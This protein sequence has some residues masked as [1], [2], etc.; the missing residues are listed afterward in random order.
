[1]DTRIIKSDR[2]IVNGPGEH[3]WKVALMQ[4][5]K[6]LTM[7]VRGL[8]SPCDCPVGDTCW[9]CKENETI[10]TRVVGS[11]NL[12]A[13]GER[14]IFW[15]FISFKENHLEDNDSLQMA[16]ST[17][18]LTKWFLEEGPQLVYGCYNPKARQAGRGK[19]APC[20]LSPYDTFIALYNDSF[21]R[22]KV[23]AD[24]VDSNCEAPTTSI[25]GPELDQLIESIENGSV[26]YGDLQVAVFGGDYTSHDLPD[27]ASDM[28]QV[29]NI[30]S[31]K[32]LAVYEE[33]DITIIK[34]GETT[35][36]CVENNSIYHVRIVGGVIPLP[37][38]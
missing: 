22:P 20:K 21:V 14:F 19:M 29:Q 31:G 33:D 8:R 17:N 23:W 35:C 27:E 25:L 37:A 2:T 5:P 15:A 3:Q 32:I 16:L 34:P 10:Y 26:P 38:K 28:L 11:F 24:E 36:C 1:M 7:T 13:Q 12:D 30:S 18:D 6:I 4:D 9:Q